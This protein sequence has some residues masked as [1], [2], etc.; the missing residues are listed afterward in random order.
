MVV[1]HVDHSLHKADV[2]ADSLD[3]VLVFNPVHLRQVAPIKCL[4]WKP[5]L[6]CISDHSFGVELIF[7]LLLEGEP[8]FEFIHQFARRCGVLDC[9]NKVLPRCHFLD[10]LLSLGR[11]RLTVAD[12]QEAARS[13][14][15]GQ[16]FFSQRL[17]V[18]KVPAHALPV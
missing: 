8:I 2:V 9:L 11:V 17:R 14:R 3:V 16:L 1:I 15:V 7:D 6:T 10:A 12:G 18:L 4:V 13:D 5:E